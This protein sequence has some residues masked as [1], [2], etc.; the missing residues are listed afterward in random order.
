MD[1]L[2]EPLELGSDFE[3]WTNPQVTITCD[4]GY[5]CGTGTVEETRP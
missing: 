4:Q 2:L 5:S 3:R 1:F